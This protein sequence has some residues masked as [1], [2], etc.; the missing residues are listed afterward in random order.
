M[1][2]GNR[3]LVYVMKPTEIKP[4]AAGGYGMEWSFLLRK[5]HLP[6]NLTNSHE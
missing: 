3:I 4:D 1:I 2:L 5:M 6:E